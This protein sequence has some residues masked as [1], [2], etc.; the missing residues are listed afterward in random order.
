ML[1]KAEMLICQSHGTEW[2]TSEHPEAFDGF[3]AQIAE[4]DLVKCICHES[5]QFS[6]QKAEGYC[7]FFPVHF[8]HSGDDI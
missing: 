6:S 2:L 3:L 1:T 5:T 8:P 7:I 4:F